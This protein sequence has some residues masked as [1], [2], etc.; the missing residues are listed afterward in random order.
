MPTNETGFQ[1]FHKWAK[2]NA[3]SYTVSYWEA[4]DNFEIEIHSAA[5]AERYYEKRVYDF[6]EFI[7]HWRKHMKPTVQAG[8]KTE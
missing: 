7:R 2:E 8:Q 6:Q 1:E 5:E 4:S 3:L